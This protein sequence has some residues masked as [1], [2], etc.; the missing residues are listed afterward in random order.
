MPRVR[1]TFFAS[2]VKQLRVVGGVPGFAPVQFK[3]L[4]SVY[5]EV[6]DGSRGIHV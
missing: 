5:N 6:P 4:W 1:P 3:G 2:G